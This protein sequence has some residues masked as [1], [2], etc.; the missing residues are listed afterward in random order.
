[1]TDDVDYGELYEAAPSGL[2]TTG[3][4]GRIVSANRTFREWT[5]LTADVLGTRRLAT[6]L[7]SGS[8]L[9]YENR[10]LP[11]ALLRREILEASL[12]LTR[13]GREPLP[14]LL[15]CTALDDAGGGLLLHHVMMDATGRSDYEQQLR[16]A[17]EE[18]E[19]ARQRLTVLQDATATF[20]SCAS[21]S[22]LATALVAV[23]GRA[24]RAQTVLARFHDEPGA[25]AVTAGEKALARFASQADAPGVP[26][27]LCPGER[28]R[29]LERLGVKAVSTVPL[30]YN[31]M[32][33]GALVCGYQRTPD[34]D[35]AFVDLQG[36]IGLAAAQALWRLRLQN[37]LEALALLDPL[38][39]L[40]NIARLRV[41]LD[42]AMVTLESTGEPCSLILIDLDD[43]KS[44]N[45]TLGHVAGNLVLQAISERLRATV[46][47]ADT[48]ARMGGDEFVILCSRTT[49][50]A[51][52]RIAART[53][54]ELSRPIVLEGV[55]R[56][57]TASIGVATAEAGT[58]ATPREL[59][60]SADAAMYRAKRTGKNT[61]AA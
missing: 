3:A 46:R 43:F 30:L 61:V 55:P 25:S 37:R 49:T 45:D 12:R 57:I 23:A 15:S 9:F 35:A 59:F 32:S 50:A 40:H 20:A 13:S 47:G 24:F 7:E 28:T 8:R 33:I 19:A 22:S 38:T 36:A 48:I 31:G 14:V 2:V 29:T 42:E 10:L 51:A 4:D 21:E 16:R 6:L 1:M 53:L 18:A 60:R 58:G 52:R 44:V 5:G 39:G 56:Q 41:A 34:A 26:H 17:R 27:E 54:R 11:T